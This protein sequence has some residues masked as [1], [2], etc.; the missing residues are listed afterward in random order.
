LLAATPKE[1]QNKL[2]SYTG[3]EIFAEVG[4]FS[5]SCGRRHKRLFKTVSK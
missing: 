4:Y 2:S 5:G 3:N 1:R